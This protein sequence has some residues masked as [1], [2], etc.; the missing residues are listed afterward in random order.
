MQDFT[1]ISIVF[2]K[3]HD[4]LNSLNGKDIPLEEKSAMIHKFCQKYRKIIKLMPAVIKAN[5]VSKQFLK[6]EEKQ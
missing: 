1:A 3:Y 4:D 2:K 5:E 6:E